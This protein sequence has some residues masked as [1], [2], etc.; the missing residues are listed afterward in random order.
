MVAISGTVHPALANLVTA[1]PRKL[2]DRLIGKVR[3]CCGAKDELHF[4]HDITPE[5]RDTVESGED[6]GDRIDGVRRLAW[7]HEVPAGVSKGG[8]RLVARCGSK[9]RTDQLGQGGRGLSLVLPEAFDEGVHRKEFAIGRRAV[10]VVASDWAGT[11]LAIEFAGVATGSARA[12]LSVVGH[13][14]TFPYVMFGLGEES[15]RAA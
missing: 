13:G 6:L 2:P 1:V 11:V 3:R 15:G 4:D 10:L 7:E 14:M 5:W 8:R 9:P 12:A